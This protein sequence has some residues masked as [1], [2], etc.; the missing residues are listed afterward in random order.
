MAAD[1]NNKLMQIIDHCSTASENL[2]RV[3]IAYKAT[4]VEGTGCRNN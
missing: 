4:D 1:D 2:S 3:F